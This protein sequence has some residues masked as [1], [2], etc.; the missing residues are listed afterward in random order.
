MLPFANR[1]WIKNREKQIYELLH[2]TPP[3]GKKYAEFVKHLIERENFWVKW[4]N[5]GCPKFMR[6]K[7]AEIA[8]PVKKK[9]KTIYDDIMNDSKLGLGSQELTRLWGKSEG[10]LEA[11]RTPKRQFIPTISDFFEEAMMHANPANE[12]EDK[13]KCYLDPAYGWRSLRLLAHSS[14]LFFSL[15]ARVTFFFEILTDR[16]PSDYKGG[17]H[18]DS[19]IEG[20]KAFCIVFFVRTKD[21]QKVS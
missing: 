16:P 18:K 1:E 12:I 2:E 8:E 3:N 13:Y 5:E 11:C 10:N 17:G 15:Q 19:L 9:R 4:K 14:P 20:T 21:L 6:E 7:E